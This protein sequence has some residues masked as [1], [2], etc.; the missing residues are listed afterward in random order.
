MSLRLHN[1]EDFNTGLK[2]IITYEVEEMLRSISAARTDTQ[3]H[4]AVHDVRKALKKIR[5]CLRL[6]RYEV[7]F[8]ERENVFFRDMGREISALRDA[9]AFLEALERL[10]KQ[11][12]SEL[13]KDSFTPLRK[14]ILAYR[15]NLAK[16]VFKEDQ[17]LEKIT[18]ALKE[19]IPR[20]SAWHLQIEAFDSVGAGFQKV[21]RRGRESLFTCRASGEATD[22]HQ[23]RKRAKYLS[24]QVEILN[25]I[26][27]QPMKALENELHDI[28]DLTGIDHDLHNLVNFVQEKRNS[29]ADKKEERIFFQMVEKQQQLMRSQALIKGGKVYFETPADF[30]SRISRY[31]HQ[32]QKELNIPQP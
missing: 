23:W 17:I 12:I 19:G 16:K 1:D 15:R 4:V 3:R 31:W 14:E 28:T 20:I 10:K 2:R 22:F 27:P 26:W 29:F 5:A 21:Y 30:Y 13:T 24:Y 9:T 11:Y 7:G 18:E 8:Y 25:R 32:H 6:V